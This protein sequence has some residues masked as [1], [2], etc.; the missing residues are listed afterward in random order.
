MSP[1]PRAALSLVPALWVVAMVMV[2]LVWGWQ[3]PWV[4]P[5]ASFLPE[6]PTGVGAAAC[7][8]LFAFLPIALLSRSLRR[9]DAL[10]LAPLGVAAVVA[11]L[12][13]IRPGFPIG[14]PLSLL[15]VLGLMVRLRPRLPSLPA[16]IE[17]WALIPV[18]A[19]IALAAC[20]P[21]VESDGLRYHL[22]APQEWIRGGGLVLLPYSANSNLPGLQSLLAMGLGNAPALG[23]TYQL[24]SAGSGL[25]LALL[26]GELARSLLRSL[27]SSSPVAG[28]ADVPV[29][30]MAALVCLTL[31]VVAILSAWPFSDVMSAAFLLAAVVRLLPGTKSR[32]VARWLTAGLLLGA[33]CA[34]KLSL[35]PLAAIVG[36]WGTVAAGRRAGVAF[37]CMALGGIVPLAPWLVRNVMNHG[38]PIYPLAYGLFGGPEWSAANDAFYKAKAAEKGM[39]RDLRA[40]VMLPWN[41][42]VN[43]RAFEGHTPGPALL[44][45]LPL[46]VVGALRARLRR[47]GG[48]WPVSLLLVV[49]G[50]GV[51]F[52]TYQSVRFLIPVVA[53]LTAVGVAVVTH[54]ALGWGKRGLLVA[55]VGL[56]LMAFAGFFWSTYY[57]TAVVPVLQ[58]AT[59]RVGAY[60]YI[61]ARFNGY[62]GVKWLEENTEPNEPVFY[63]GEHRAFYSA[64]H[65]PILSDWFDTPRVLVE[66]RDTPDNDALLERWRGQGIRFVFLNMAELGQYEAIYFKSRFSPTEWERFES[67]RRWLLERIVH[68]DQPGVL[69][70]RITPEPT[71]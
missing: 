6:F 2:W 21:A 57:T 49:G 63:I 71:S 20:A 42:T 53:V 65:R 28:V 33:A 35:L 8:A 11:G 36:V 10:T 67:L 22:A 64:H 43:Y 18:V 46:V 15:V 47:I 4:Q 14:G 25:M 27:A 13:F 23:P 51:W 59:G 48:P 62:G 7:V 24:L 12:A 60:P 52:M 45:F 29:A 37:G 68:E 39:G 9:V 70:C 3:L 61:A 50:L 69:I 30:A 1:F 54:A 40:L 41:A 19:V 16:S 5:M 58:A 26:T 34:T 56:G 55:R 66:I 38:N 44:A 17:T 32:P 31:P